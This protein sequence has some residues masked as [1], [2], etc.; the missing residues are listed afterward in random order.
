M[1]EKNGRF[2]A[3]VTDPESKIITSVRPCHRRPEPPAIAFQ[4]R[5]GHPRHLTRQ[6]SRVVFHCSA[7]YQHSRQRVCFCRLSRRSRIVPALAPSA[8]LS[9]L[10][11]KCLT[12]QIYRQ[13]AVVNRAKGNCFSKTADSIV[14]CAVNVT[15][16]RQ[17][18]RRGARTAMKYVALVQKWQTV[19]RRWIKKGLTAWG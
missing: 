15:H 19:A 14:L 11:L 2:A 3:T 5:R 9:D 7:S 8:A 4:S 1:G 10:G 17:R 13:R 16:C 18:R 12:Q 6:V